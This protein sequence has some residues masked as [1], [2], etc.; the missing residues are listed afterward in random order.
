MRDSQ[1]ADCVEQ[2]HDVNDHFHVMMECVFASF[3]PIVKLLPLFFRVTSGLVVFV[4]QGKIIQRLLLEQPSLR[5]V[6]PVRTLR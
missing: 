6:Q 5:D 4:Y 2:T 1:T 3:H